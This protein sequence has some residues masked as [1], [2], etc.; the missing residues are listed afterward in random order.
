MQVG[1]EGIGRWPVGGC[2]NREALGCRTAVRGDAGAVLL[3]SVGSSYYI[4]KVETSIYIFVKSYDAK[5]FHCH[6]K[7]DTV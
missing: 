3:R 5:K 1:G 6:S 2:A 4:A 7:E